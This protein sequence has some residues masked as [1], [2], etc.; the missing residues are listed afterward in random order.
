MWQY[1]GAD[2]VASDELLE[3]FVGFVYLIT[4]LDTGKMYVGKKNFWSTRKLPP[5]KGQKRKRTV[6]RQS[7]WREYFGSNETLKLLVEEKGP[8]RY[9]RE[10]L[11]LCKSK[12]DLSYEELLEQVRRD[13]LRDDRYYNGIIQVRISSSHLLKDEK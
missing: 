3:Q 4:D 1:C 2:F 7:D 12:G 13:V 6:R 5:L 11:K 9:E 10:I 8:E